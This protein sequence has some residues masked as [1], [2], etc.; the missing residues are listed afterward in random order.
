MRRNFFY[1]NPLIIIIG[2]FML[3]VCLSY[4]GWHLYRWFNWNYGYS[5]MVKETIKEMVKE[6]CLKK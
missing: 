3:T 4:G 6:E 2:G 5:S 1:I